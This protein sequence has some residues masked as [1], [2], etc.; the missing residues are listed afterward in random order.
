MFSPALRRL[1]NRLPP[2]ERVKPKT[3][4]KTGGGWNVKVSDADALALLRRVACGESL[5]SVAA[6]ACLNE[7]TLRQW[8]EGINRP[9]LA[10]QLEKERRA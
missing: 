3:L 9:T 8:Y 2:N 10:R 7:T 1:A 5:S 4:K 6:S